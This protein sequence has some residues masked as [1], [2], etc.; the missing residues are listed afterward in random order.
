MNIISIFCFG[1]GILVGALILNFIASFLGF[2]S[3]YDFIK[4]T[5]RASLLSYLWLFIFYPLGLGLSAYLLSK[6]ISL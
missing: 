2:M 1:V 4:G 5:E 6:F 3:W